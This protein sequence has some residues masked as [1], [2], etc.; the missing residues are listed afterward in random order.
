MLLRL[1]NYMK[2][3]KIA[4]IITLCLIL[5]CFVVRSANAQVNWM[6]EYDFVYLD[7]VLE[8]AQYEVRYG[9]LDNFIGKPIEGY[10]SDRLVLTRQAAK[11]LKEV[12][13]KLKKKGYCLKLFDTYRP[14]RAVNHFVAWSKIEGDT[15]M[16]DAYYPK[17][18]KEHLF[19]LGYISTRSGHTRGSTIDLTVAYLKNGEEIDMG[20]PYDFFGELSH[21]TY[22]ELSQEQLSN[23]LILKNVMENAGFRSYSKEWWHYTLNGEPYPKQYFDFIVPSVTSK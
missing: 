11:A 7:E 5:A 16:K 9:S 3:L 6:E 2:S 1:D 8:F 14:Q 20:G 12:E 21:H 4:K 19:K 22:T 15:L 17:P 18:K 23:R 10:N 13:L